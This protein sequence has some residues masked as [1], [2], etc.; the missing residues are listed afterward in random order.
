MPRRNRSNG[1]FTK[2]TRRRPR[3]KSL[4]LLGVAETALVANAVTSGMFNANLMDFF[5][6]R[7]DGVY[8]AGT[9]GTYRV[10]I[11]EMITGVT[12]AKNFDGGLSEIIVHNVKKNASDLAVGAIGI[13]LAF[14]FAKKFLAK[15]LINPTNKML[16]SV[17]IN[18]VKL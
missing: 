9:D 1:R 14:R 12:T 10:T 16:R 11:P 13:P 18:E 2:Q 7:R 5:T 4:N 15:P 6:G 8:R 3:K 17:G